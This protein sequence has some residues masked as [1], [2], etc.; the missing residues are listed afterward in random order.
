[1]CEFLLLLLYYSISPLYSTQFSA[2][3]TRTSVER[4]ND[5]V[6]LTPLPALRN[7]RGSAE[8]MITDDN[9]CK[10]FE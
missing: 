9:A 2:R 5:F 3:G 1:M 6:Y 10:S 8:R 4:N 7:I